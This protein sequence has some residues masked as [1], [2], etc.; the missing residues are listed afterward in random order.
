MDNYTTDTK[1]WLND[2]F[3]ATDEEGIYFAHQPI[4]GFRKG[5]SEPGIIIRYII[6]Y[7]IMKM[8]YNS[9]KY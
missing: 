2:R 8:E 3:K 5:H 7:Q 9:L 1:D 6:T 4:Y